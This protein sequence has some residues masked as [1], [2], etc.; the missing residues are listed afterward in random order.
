MG[1]MKT[2]RFSLGGLG[3]FGGF[4]GEG[5][6]GADRYLTPTGPNRKSCP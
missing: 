2:G 4:F 6:N 5:G 3:F 1:I